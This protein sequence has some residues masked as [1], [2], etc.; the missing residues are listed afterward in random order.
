MQSRQPEK[1]YWIPN[2]YILWKRATQ[3]CFHNDILSFKMIEIKKQHALPQ[4][5]VFP[6]Y[7]WPDL[8]LLISILMLL[9]SWWD[10][11]NTNLLTLLRLVQSSLTTDSTVWVL[12]SEIFWGF[13]L[14]TLTVWTGK[15]HHADFCFGINNLV[16][17]DSLYELQI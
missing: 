17:V 10:I 16:L 5:V 4:T 11:L 15:I 7:L 8:R 1:L 12:L 13:F 3:F 14:Y 2:K 9:L 6:L